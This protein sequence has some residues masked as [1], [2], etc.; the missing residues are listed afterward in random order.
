MAED[1]WRGSG[2]MTSCESPKAEVRGHL[3][4]LDG[5]NIR[6]SDALFC[7]SLAFDGILRREVP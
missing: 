1:A 5:L 3:Y 7:R 6:I 4:L 2:S